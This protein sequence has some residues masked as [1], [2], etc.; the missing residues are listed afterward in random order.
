MKAPAPKRIR[1]DVPERIRR[2]MKSTADLL[3]LDDSG[4]ALFESFVVRVY[5]A[6]ESDAMSVALKMAKSRL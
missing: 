2:D 6:G 4:R 5:V 1:P 3:G